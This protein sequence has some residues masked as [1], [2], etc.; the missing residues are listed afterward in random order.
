MKILPSNS[1]DID[2]IFELYDE[3]IAFQKKVS[4]Q[5][6]L[7]FEKDMV[8]NEIKNGLQWKIVYGDEIACVFAIAFSDPEIWKEKNSDPAIYIHRIVTKEKYRGKNLVGNI[9]DWAKEYGR[10]K[11]KNYVRMD[12]WGDNPKLKEYYMKFGFDFLGIIKPANVD[13]LPAHYSAI[14]LALFQLPITE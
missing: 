14:S 10:T 3:A 2:I 1:Q 6:W 9:V 5:H 12:T 8:K 13:Q 7:P 4:N 11:H